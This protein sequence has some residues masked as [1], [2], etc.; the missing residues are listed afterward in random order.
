MMANL[1]VALFCL[2]AIPVALI[3]GF[4]F[5]AVINFIFAILNFLW[6]FYALKRKDK[7]L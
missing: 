5:L 4:M 1:V 3:N 2:I 6:G 7:I